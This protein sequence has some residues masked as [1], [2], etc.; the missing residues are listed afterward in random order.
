MIIWQFPSI[1]THYLLFKGM[2]LFV[3]VYEGIVFPSTNGGV[4]LDIKNGFKKYIIYEYIKINLDTV[5][6]SHEEK[7]PSF[8][9][10]IRLVGGISQP[11]LPAIPVIA[12][13]HPR[14]E[15]SR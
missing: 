15:L 8:L 11:W 13:H 12:F 9:H 4:G 5:E 1:F 14:R 7:N 3:F 6:L 10:S 2:R